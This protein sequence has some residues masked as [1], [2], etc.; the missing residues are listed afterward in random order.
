MRLDVCHAEVHASVLGLVGLG[1]CFAMVYKTMHGLEIVAA[2]EII[3]ATET[4]D[5]R[6]TFG[7]IV[8]VPTKSVQHCCHPE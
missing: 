8:Q 5:V 1:V 7:I 6:E 3:K 4:V 2:C